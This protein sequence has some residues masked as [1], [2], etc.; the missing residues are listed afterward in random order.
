VSDYFVLRTVTVLLCVKL[1]LPR[2]IFSTCAIE[3]TMQFS[4]LSGGSHKADRVEIVPRRHVVRPGVWLPE[5]NCSAM[6]TPDELSSVSWELSAA[7]A[8]NNED[9]D[10]SPIVINPL[11]GRSSVL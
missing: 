1:A 6:R 5:V 7:H 4:R 3:Q 9:F 10:V 11:D 8:D 2:L